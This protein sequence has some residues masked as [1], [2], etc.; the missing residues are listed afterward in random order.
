ML[1][2]GWVAETIAWGV[3]GGIIVGALLLARWFMARER[4]A[5]ALLMLPV[6]LFGLIFAVSKW[7]NGTRVL[8]VGQDQAGR[9]SRTDLR[10]YGAEDYRYRNGSSGDLTCRDSRHIV[11]NDTPYPLVLESV[12]YGYGV[13]T[14][15]PIGG[16][17][18]HCSEGIVTNFG[19]GEAPP[20]KIETTEYGAT[21]YW[22]HW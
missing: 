2:P 1:V 6:A 18:R 13:S 16:F 17:S 19:P 11:V 21:K 15:E 4:K 14:S 20:P 5:A 8:I 7:A 9:A 10:L 12:R 22:L 3:G